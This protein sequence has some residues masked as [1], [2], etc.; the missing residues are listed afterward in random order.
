MGDYLGKGERKC[1]ERVKER[2]RERACRVT[3]GKVMCRYGGFFFFFLNAEFKHR[4]KLGVCMRCIPERSGCKNTVMEVWGLSGWVSWP[5]KMTPLHSSMEPGLHKHISIPLNCTLH[6]RQPD[7]LAPI[8]S[9]RGV[10]GLPAPGHRHRR[11][12][13]WF[14]SVN[15]SSYVRRYNL[16]SGCCRFHRKAMSNVVELGEKR[17]KKLRRRILMSS[18]RMCT[19]SQAALF[20]S[21]SRY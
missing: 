12:T 5:K 18:A 4:P 6:L 9:G 13:Q 15:E 3:W 2:E 14:V 20:Y 17:R 19:W 7:N 21:R 8:R 16:F 1:G 10:S 11:R